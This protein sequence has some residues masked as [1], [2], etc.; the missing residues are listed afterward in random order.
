MQ[1][2]QKCPCCHKRISFRELFSAWTLASKNSD[3]LVRCPQ[4]QQVVQ[5]L[6]IY[7]KYGL[8]GALP[9]FGVPLVYSS[10]YIGYIVGFG[11]LMY[12][13]LLFWFLYMK[14]PLVC[15]GEYSPKELQKGTE[16]D[17]RINHYVVGIIAIVFFVSIISMFLSF[18][19]TMKEKNKQ[20]A[21]EHTKESIHFFEK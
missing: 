4:C 10:P 9:L 2:T 17:S 20:Q 3:K 5:E 7:E 21:D 1:L 16:K 13:F 15:Q 11:S 18:A 19:T 12:I 14:I 8:L 6:A